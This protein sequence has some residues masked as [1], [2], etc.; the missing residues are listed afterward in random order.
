M[1]SHA[2]QWNGKESDVYQCA[3]CIGTILSSL[4]QQINTH[5]IVVVAYRGEHTV[6][7]LQLL[8][9]DVPEQ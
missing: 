1:G 3:A 5:L 7:K 8:I 2:Q 4:C 9:A 6:E